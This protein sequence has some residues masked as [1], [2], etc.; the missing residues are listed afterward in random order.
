MIEVYKYTHGLYKTKQI[1]ELD[2]DTTRR[3]HNLKLR[4]KACRTSTRQNF[5][6]YR[7]VSPW[8]H[9]PSKVVNAPSLNSFKSRLDSA[10]Q[11]H[12]YS[13]NLDYPLPQAKIK[14]D[15]NMRTVKTS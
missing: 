14:S 6:T 7:V 8:N 15:D 5:F 4:K 13:T 10:W 2:P 9:L 3:G 12:R 1:L 11:E